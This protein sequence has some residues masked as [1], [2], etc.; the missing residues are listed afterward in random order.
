MQEGYPEVYKEFGK[1]GISCDT[2]YVDSSLQAWL[3]PA[4]MVYS[5][6]PADF[7]FKLPETSIFLGDASALAAHLKAS[8]D[9]AFP[10]VHGAFGEDGQL[11]A[12]L[13]EAGVPFVGSPPEASGVAFNKVLALMLLAPDGIYC[14]AFAPRIYCSCEPAVTSASAGHLQRV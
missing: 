6:T 12:A 7:E 1:H 13:R 9:I 8:V 10:V 3:V 2:Y 5:R 14:F 4:S 11:G